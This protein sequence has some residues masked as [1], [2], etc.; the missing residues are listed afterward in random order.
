M[1]N[2]LRNFASIYRASI[3]HISGI[4]LNFSAMSDIFFMFVLALFTLNILT[5]TLIVFT[6]VILVLVLFTS[7]GF[8]LTIPIIMISCSI[9]SSVVD[10][11]KTV[12]FEGVL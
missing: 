3:Y 7:I 4:T 10:S 12:F 11:L 2:T 5:L 6:P 8:I 1:V 9:I